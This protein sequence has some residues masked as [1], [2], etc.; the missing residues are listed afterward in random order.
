M[1][2]NDLKSQLDRDIL[3]TRQLQEKMIDQRRIEVSSHVCDGN[4]PLSLCHGAAS[5]SRVTCKDVDPLLWQ[6]SM[7]NSVLRR[8]STCTQWHRS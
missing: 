7:Q 2:L 5:I 3:E 1:E 6:M 8:H 4:H